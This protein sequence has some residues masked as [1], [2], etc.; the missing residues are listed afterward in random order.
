MFLIPPRFLSRFAISFWR[1]ATSFFGKHIKGAVFLHFLKAC[2]TVNAH[3]DGLVV[4]EHS[5]EPTYV[6]IVHS[7]ALSLFA[8]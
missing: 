1:E 5:A 4:G 8:G 3:S 2:E 6:D 7:A